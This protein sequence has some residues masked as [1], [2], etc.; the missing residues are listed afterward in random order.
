MSVYEDPYSLKNTTKQQRI[1]LI[2]SWSNNEDDGPEGCEIDLWDMYADYISGTKEIA[3][4]NAA[5][6]PDY[7]TEP[8]DSFS[9]T[10][11][12]P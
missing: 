1:G 2:R 5:F 11:A 10:G 9:G 8:E 12:G 4:C 7:Y 6:R 3:E